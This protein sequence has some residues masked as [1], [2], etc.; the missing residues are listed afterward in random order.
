M[1]EQ[2]SSQITTVIQ[3]SYPD[4]D[5][6]TIAINWLNADSIIMPTF[7]VGSVRVSTGNRDFMGALS[8]PVYL[9]SLDKTQRVKRT[10]LVNVS[11][12]QPYVRLVRDINVNEPISLAHVELVNRPIQDMPSQAIR[13]TQ[14]IIGLTA[15]SRLLRGTFLTTHMI[16][17]VYTVRS[18]QFIV[19]R[20]IR[21][22][23][24]IE[25]D[26]MALESGGLG[27]II[28]VRSVN[29]QETLKGEIVGDKT[30][31]IRL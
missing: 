21:D 11:A 10:V 31:E 8:V 22:T 12:Q 26:G 2:I 23:I 3:S 28:L 24:E 15:S 7:N 27:D 29:Y 20:V 4:V 25:L 6:D 5:R 30:V 9:T 17:P 19:L 14:D 18:G 16:Q 13:V 1:S